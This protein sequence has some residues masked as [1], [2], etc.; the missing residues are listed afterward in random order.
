[1][2]ELFKWALDNK[3]TI[4]QLLTGA[5]TVASLVATLTPNNSDNAWVARVNKVVSW[6]ALNIGKAKSTPEK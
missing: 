6:V 5:V 4:I 3:E 1:M 2:T